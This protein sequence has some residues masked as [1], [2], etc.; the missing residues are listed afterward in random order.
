MTDLLSPRCAMAWGGGP[1]E[2]CGY[3]PWRN[4]TRCRQVGAYHAQMDERLRAPRTAPEPSPPPHA[5]NTSAP[6]T[7]AVTPVVGHTPVPWRLNHTFNIVG[8][9]DGRRGIATAG[10][11]MDTRLPDCGHA[12]NVTN[13]A[14]IVLAANHH[15]ALV[16]AL[17]GMIEDWAWMSDWE[18]TVTQDASG[19]TNR[20]KYTRILQ[21]RSLLASVRG[22]P[23][24]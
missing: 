16:E 2:R 22:E 17:E 23:G 6:P 5:P 9:P 11:F 14:F 12:E 18:I 24:K 1:C 4:N 20:K 15:A 3:D 7:D 10:G 19:K 13:A 21:A 8:G